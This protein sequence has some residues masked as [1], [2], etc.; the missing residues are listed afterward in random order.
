K[1]YLDIMYMPTVQ[2]YKYIVAAR[3]NLSQV[4]EG[5]ALRKATFSAVTKFLWEEIFC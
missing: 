4:A 2:G 1:I 5:R 3:D